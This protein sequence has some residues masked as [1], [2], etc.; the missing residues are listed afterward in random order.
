MSLAQ[1]FAG[2]ENFL[3]ALIRLE[4]G[5]LTIETLPEETKGQAFL[6]LIGEIEK[7]FNYNF[8]ARRVNLA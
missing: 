8:N 6:S 7:N 4:E 3:K 5:L 1:N 2:Q